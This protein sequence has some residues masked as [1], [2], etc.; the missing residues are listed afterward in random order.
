MKKN[1]EFQFFFL[2]NDSK[3]NEFAMYAH[4]IKPELEVNKSYHA[5]VQPEREKWMNLKISDKII[6][7]RGIHFYEFKP[8]AM[9]I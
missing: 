7:L 2:S 8:S 3:W 5:T 9:F 6:F 4:H 1:L